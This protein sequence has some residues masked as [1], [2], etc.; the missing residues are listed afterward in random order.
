[1]SKS[2]KFTKSMVL[3]NA[4][5]FCFEGEVWVR[6]VNGVTARMTEQDTDL[7]RELDDMISRLFPKAHEALQIIYRESSSNIWYY[8]F[9]IVS[10]FI[11]CNRSNLDHVPDVSSDGRLNLESVA[12]PMRGE[13]PYEDVV[14]RPSFDKAL[15][16]AEFRVMERLYD[17]CSESEIADALFLSVFT[18]R[19]HVRNALSRLGLRSRAE[20]MKYAASNNLFYD[21]KV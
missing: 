1:M 11:R 2:M 6:H 13:C 20:F 5:F 21:G 14:C 7:I 16:P 4:E 9:R 3:A 19:T 10:R 15:S 18:V 12:C 8:R 17:G